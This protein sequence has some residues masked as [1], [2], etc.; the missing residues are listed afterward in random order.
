MEY[1]AKQRKIVHLLGDLRI[2]IAHD[3]KSLHGHR[4][5]VQSPH[6]IDE[7]DRSWAADVRSPADVR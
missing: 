7:K 6:D 2:K 1:S 4:E 5:A 3:K